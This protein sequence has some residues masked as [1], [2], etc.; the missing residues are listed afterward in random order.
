MYYCTKSLSTAKFAYWNRLLG[1]FTKLSR[2]RLA[3]KTQGNTTGRLVRR[4]VE[5]RYREE[6]LVLRV[7]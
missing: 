3:R 4:L 7:C 5:K 1:S 2:R 6:V